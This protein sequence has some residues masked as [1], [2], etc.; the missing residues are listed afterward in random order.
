MF[1]RR[2]RVRSGTDTTPV[3]KKPSFDFSVTGLV[4]CSMMMFMGVAAINSQTNLLFAVFGLMLGVLWVS[5]MVSRMVL[6]GLEVRRDFPEH[7]AV[8]QRATLQYGI[9]N[10]KR[11]WP[12]LSVFLAE[13]EG[14]EAFTTQVQAYMLHAAAGM[15]AVV[16]AVVVAKRRGLHVLGR[17]QIGT[18]FP[19]GFLKRAVERQQPGRVLVYPAIGQVSPRL[20]SLCVSAESS[21]STMKPRRGGTDEFYGLREFR[22]GESPRLIYWRRTART[23]DLVA[24]E[25]TQVAPP[26]LILLV[27]THLRDRRPATHEAVERT[28]AMAASLADHALSAGLSVGLVVWAGEWVAIAPNRGKRHARDVLATL[29]KLPLN[30][31]HDLSQ[32]VA[33]TNRLRAA[34]TTNVLLTPYPQ[35]LGLADQSRGNWLL[36]SAASD[37]ARQWFRFDPEVDF[38]RCMPADQRPREQAAAWSPA[39]AAAR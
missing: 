1:G 14:T 22:D 3:R 37:Q 12:S 30:E 35:S 13:L 24:R 19:F 26:R 31:R 34:A 36:I 8:G 29:A 11:F 7:L 23:G 17:Y 15:T 20:L 32:L 16:P 5:G 33:H 4:Y 28:I 27:E 10:H 38:S 25:M 9:T 18:S 2:R 39:G 21:T 6:R